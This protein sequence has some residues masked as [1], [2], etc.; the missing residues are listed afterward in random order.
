MNI[1]YTNPTEQAQTGLPS[2][3][4]W[5]NIPSR[6]MGEMNRLFDRFGFW[7]MESSGKFTPRVEIAE[8]EKS[9]HV[10]AELPGVDRN[11]I[12]LTITRDSLVIKGKKED[13][14]HKNAGEIACSERTYGEFSRVISLPQF[15]DVDKVEAKYH[16]GVLC[17][18]LPKIEGEKSFR[19][20]Q[21]GSP[22][23]PTQ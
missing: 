10:D 19:K 5:G 16:N 22:E 12:D 20:I 15:V 11:D 2:S 17:I 4:E 6:L 23:S 1:R 7:P 9:F 18:N 8:D 14:E 13:I 21:V 3:R